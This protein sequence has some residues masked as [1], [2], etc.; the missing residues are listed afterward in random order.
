M[1]DDMSDLAPA[2]LM[3]VIIAIGYSVIQQPWHA[4]TKYL[5]VLLATM[6]VC[7]VLYET[8][9]RRTRPTRALFGMKTASPAPAS[10]CAEK[11]RCA[12]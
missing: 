6:G 1:H 3:T 12:P 10:V 4:W 7:A 2:L 8:C 5:V 11:V 9:V